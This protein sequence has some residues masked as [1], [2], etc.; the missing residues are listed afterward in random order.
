MY[1]V[2]GL[3]DVMDIQNKGLQTNTHIHPNSQ[4]KQTQKQ[5]KTKQIDDLLNVKVR[6]QRSS[7]LLA[8]LT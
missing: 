8:I 1:H 7:K 2:L 6:M 5:S 3:C 4:A